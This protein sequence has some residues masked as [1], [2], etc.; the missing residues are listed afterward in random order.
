MRSQRRRGRGQGCRVARRP[1]GVPDRGDGVAGI[2]RHRSPAVD[3]DRAMGCRRA[4]SSARVSP[5]R[6]GSRKA[7]SSRRCRPPRRSS[8]SRCSPRSCSAWMFGRWREA[9]VVIYAVVG[10]TA[11][12]MATTMLIDR[13][14]PECGA[15]RRRTADVVI[16]VR[17]H[18]RSGVLLRFGRRDRGMAQH[19]AV[20]QRRR[21]N[22]LRGSASDDRRQSR[23]PRHALPDGC[24]GR[25]ASR[26]AVVERRDLLRA[27][28]QRR[29][30]PGRRRRRGREAGERADARGNHRQPREIRRDRPA[31]RRRQ[32]AGLRRLVAV[33]VAGDDADGS[34]LR[35]GRDRR[36]GGRGAGGDLWRRR[37]G[38]GV[39][40]CAQQHRPARCG[41][42]ARQRQPACPKSRNSA[43][44]RRVA[45]CRRQR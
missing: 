39:P 40:R 42:P 36:R 33:P 7:R 4:A 34:R 26:G 9:L 2:P 20:G 21:R 41:A 10:E 8:S 25:R 30:A 35:N 38:D 24:D 3:R 45:G 16:P 43:R 32:D 31:R 44:I 1:G 15:P 13:P 18:R 28:A 11:I 6:R 23:V 22:P 29:R 27:A 5:A 19:E 12:F 17:P 37:H 14:R